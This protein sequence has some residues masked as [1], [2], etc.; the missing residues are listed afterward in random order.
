MGLSYTERLREEAKTIERTQRRMDE[1]IDARRAERQAK[2][3]QEAAERDAK[4]AE[5]RERAD[6]RFVARLR[7]NYL[8]A[9]PSA[10]ED[11][12]RRDLPEIRRQHRIA[13]A[14]AGDSDA[15]A[16]DLAARR[17]HARLYQGF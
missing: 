16:A 17:A 2:E 7:D 11:D 1:L 10:T 4:E 15:A 6:A 9:D 12:F 13:A 5:R 8:A 3:E 14:T